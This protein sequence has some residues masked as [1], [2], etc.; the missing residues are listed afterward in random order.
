VRY[1]ERTGVVTIG[2]RVGQYK[3]MP[4]KREF[5]VRV[6]RPGAAPAADLDAFDKAV[7]YDGKPVTVKL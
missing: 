7:S 4:L 3:G 2:E 5:R 6:L 1:D